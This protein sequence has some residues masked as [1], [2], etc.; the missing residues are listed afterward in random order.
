[1]TFTWEVNV[2]VWVEAETPTDAERMVS[3]QMDL[4]VKGGGIDSF[5]L[6]EGVDD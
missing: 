2:T 4:L 6:E 5:E 3:E 1:M